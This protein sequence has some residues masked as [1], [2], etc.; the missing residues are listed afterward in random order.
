MPDAS[1]S[2]VVEGRAQVRDRLGASGCVRD[3]LARS[4]RSHGP[5]AAGD[6]PKGM[7][8]RWIGT[9]KLVGLAGSI[10][11]QPAPGVA[12]PA[13]SVDFPADP[14]TPARRTVLLVLVQ[15]EQT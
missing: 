11:S 9:V 5:G 1:R 15:F 8:S 14:L 7:S 13:P 6:V 12:P 4:R 2:G 10:E 3:E